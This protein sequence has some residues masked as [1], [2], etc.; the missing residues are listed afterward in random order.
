MKEI[1][2]TKCQECGEED[3]FKHRTVDMI[4][5]IE[6][7]KERICNNCFNIMDYWAYGNW[8]SSEMEQE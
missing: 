5:Y 4:D 1:S 6:T 8:E 2:I 7:E 3:N